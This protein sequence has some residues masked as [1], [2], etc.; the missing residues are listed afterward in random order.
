MA[1]EPIK[2]RRGNPAFSKKKGELGYIENRDTVTGQLAR[3]KAAHEAVSIFPHVEDFQKVADDYFDECDERG[4]LYGEAGL[5][6]HLSE[7]N[8]KGRTVTLT[9]LRSWYDGDRCAY[10]QDAVQ[11][12]YLRIQ[13]QVETDERYREKGMVT[14]G[15]FLQKQ[16]RLGQDRAEKRH[17]GAHR[18]R[19]QRGRQRFQVRKG[20][21]VMTAML[22]VLL[23]MAAV[24]LAETS[25]L[26]AREFF[27]TKEQR[28]E[29]RVEQEMH[30]PPPDPIDEGFENIM[31]YAVNGKTG[32][33]RE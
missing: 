1:D 23:V 28:T 4:V 30:K 6:L 11:M 5:A 19:R 8:K 10:L 12:A 21:T 22:A 20:R 13:N 17:D 25:A 18:S 29:Q 33:E 2:K 3:S 9:V 24:I 27:K 26:F 7:H 15:I 14:R 16:T 32:F 31:R